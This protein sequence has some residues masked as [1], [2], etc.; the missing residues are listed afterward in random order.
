MLEHPD[1]ATRD[2]STLA[3]ISQG[4]SPVPP[5]SIATIEREFSGRVAPANGYGLTETTSAVIANSGNA[6]FAKMDSVGLP[7]P[8]LIQ[9]RDP[10]CTSPK[11]SAIAISRNTITA[12]SQCDLSPSER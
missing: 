12:Y 1:A 11:P 8:R 6:Y 2:L 10:L 9:R 3:G 7:M 5:D 4:G